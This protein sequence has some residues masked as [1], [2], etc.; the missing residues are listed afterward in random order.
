MKKAYYNKSR[1]Q[2]VK[3][4]VHYANNRVVN[5]EKARLYR[6]RWLEKAKTD[7]WVRFK[8]ISDNALKR[9]KEFSITF[10]GFLD[11]IKNPCN[12]CGGIAFGLDRVDNTLGYIPDNVV[13]C[14]GDCNMMKYKHTVD[15]F[16]S[17]IEKVYN[18]LFK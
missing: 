6:Q 2:Q 13:S 1:K 10:D 15:E 18:H 9:D 7:P 16:K 5:E 3:E 8:R 14:C 17:H 12:Y 4:A 11:I